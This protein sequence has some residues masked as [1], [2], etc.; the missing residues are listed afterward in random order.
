MYMQP[1]NFILNTSNF[2]Y[3]HTMPAHLLLKSD[4]ILLLK[5]NWLYCYT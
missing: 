5:Q 3:D 4:K 2:Q 1:L